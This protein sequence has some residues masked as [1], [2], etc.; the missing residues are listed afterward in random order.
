[1]SVDRGGPNLAR[2]FESIEPHLDFF[3]EVLADVVVSSFNTREITGRFQGRP[4]V[5]ILMSALGLKSNVERVCGLRS[6]LT[7]LRHQPRIA[8]EPPTPVSAL[9]MYSF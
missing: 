8:V 4:F 6:V 2:G 3:G 5:T 7:Q 1:M 9:S